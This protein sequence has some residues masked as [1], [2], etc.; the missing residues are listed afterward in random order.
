MVSF[1][2]QLVENR[3]LREKTKKSQIFWQLNSREKVT[4]TKITT[5]KTKKNIEKLV[6]HHYIKNGFLVDHDIKN[7]CLFSSSLLQKSEHRKECEKNIES[8]SFVWFLHFN[9]LWHHFNYLWRMVLWTTGVK[10][11]IF[12]SSLTWLNLT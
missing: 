9:Y 1:F 12:K 5:S 3:W 2:M 10:K 11:W 8:L 7:H 4:T 6:N